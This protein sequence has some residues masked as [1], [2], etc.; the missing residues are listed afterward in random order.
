MEPTP[1]PMP[2]PMP[3]PEIIYDECWMNAIGS[4]PGL[5]LADSNY[6]AWSNIISKDEFVFGN[7]YE[8]TAT[9]N[10]EYIVIKS[11]SIAE[12]FEKLVIDGL[13]VINKQQFMP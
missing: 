7:T 11:G 12:H 2:T 13:D 8:L 10:V 5:Y 9:K 1:T 3:T 6:N 4:V